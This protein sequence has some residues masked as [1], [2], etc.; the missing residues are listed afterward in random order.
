MRKTHRDALDVR[1]SGN[2]PRIILALA[3]AWFLAA[4]IR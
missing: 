3:L 4:M 1:I 2:V